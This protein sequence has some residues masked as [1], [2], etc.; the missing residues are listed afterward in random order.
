MKATLF[1]DN[2]RLK[3]ANIDTTVDLPNDYSVLQPR[4]PSAAGGGSNGFFEGGRGVY[5]KFFRSEKGKKYILDIDGAYMFS[6]VYLNEEH[7]VSRPHGYMPYL[8]DL[9]EYISEGKLNKLQIKTT[10][11]QPSTRWYSGAGLFR[12]VYL[13]EGGDIRIEPRD[14]FITTPDVSEDSAVVKVAYI[15]TA[16]RPAKTVLKTSVSSYGEAVLSAEHPLKLEVGK[17][18]GEVILT[19]SNPKL[20]SDETP[21]VYTLTAEIE[22][23]GVIIEKAGETF[24]I[25]SISATAE[26]GLLVNGRPV[27]LRGGCIH[28]DHGGLGAADYPDAVER[29]LKKLKS[30]GFNAIRSAHNP[31]SRTL[32]NI[33]DRIGL[34]VMDEAFD[35]WN[36]PK[37]DYSHHLWFAD[38]WQRDIAAMVIRDRN[39]PCVISWSVGNEI[40]ESR[41]FENG[42]RW[43]ARL[44]EEVRR[45][46]TTRFVTVCTWEMPINFDEKDPEEYISAL[47]ESLPKDS[48]ADPHGWGRRTEKYYEPFDICGYNYMYSRYASDRLLYPDRIIWGSETK[49]LEFYD[50]WKQTTENSHVLGDFTWTAYDNLG[51]TGTGRFTWKKEATTEAGAFISGYPWRTCFQGD[52][53]LAGFRRPQSYFREVIWKGNNEPKIF[54]TH[55]RHY[56]DTLTGTGWHWHDV[57]DT[58][59][60]P[61]EYIGAPVT[62]EVYTLADRVQ[63]YL[64]GRL[65]GESVPQ[66]AIA[67]FD[68]PYEKGTVSVKTY[69]NG[70]LIGE[71][72]LSTV[73][74]AAGLKLE[75][76]TGCIL[77]DGRSIAYIDI[78]EVDA[79]GNRI[80]DSSAEV[81]CEVSGGELICVFSGQPANED[82]YTSNS[83]HLYHGRAVA[84]VKSKTTGEIKV[85]VTAKD[86]KTADCTVKVTDLKTKSSLFGSNNF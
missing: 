81:S 60:Y 86:G 18:K 62:C 54:T 12:D 63:W 47:K 14:L 61:D 57:T 35:M 72:R 67:Y 17:N 55:P 13:W 77:P 80:A 48:S 66:K 73:G 5:T 56:G 23:E 42:S 24:G 4:S 43:S 84:V 65:L 29:K 3:T 85:S 79:E 16:D 33:C 6:E 30:V 10:A 22:E 37:K 8:A 76:E 82:D 50:S 41:G 83:C 39:H 74:P 38:W 1:S 20:W 51:E 68:I 70:E 7:L 49:A 58:W 32:L 75:P 31:P 46:D 19:V 26:K 2:W 27:K 78:T 44:A 34:Y 40:P 9:S 25:R 59:N 36:E 71:S 28:H 15:I 21:F 64:N 11:L 53:D 45:Y 52:F 69:K